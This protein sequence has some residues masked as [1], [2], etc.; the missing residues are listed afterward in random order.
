[1]KTSLG[2]RGS[3]S[4]DIHFGITWC[5]LP[6]LGFCYISL[7]GNGIFLILKK[8]DIYWVISATISLGI[9][10]E[11]KRLDKKNH[12]NVCVTTWFSGKVLPSDV[13]IFPSLVW[14]SHFPLYWKNWIILMLFYENNL[15][16]FVYHAYKL[17]DCE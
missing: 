7:V 9:H 15:C 16:L 17:H 5:F 6:L 8:R 11:N 13:L 12:G 2:L 3:S 10:H 14:V 4:M 1:M